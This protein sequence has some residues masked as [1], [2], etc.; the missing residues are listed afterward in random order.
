MV[1]CNKLSRNDTN[2]NALVTTDS[3]ELE[4]VQTP[5]LTNTNEISLND[6]TASAQ[7]DPQAIG[8]STYIETEVVQ[9]DTVSSK[10]AYDVNRRTIEQV[11]T[12]GATTTYQVTRKV[13]KKTIKVDTIVE[14]MDKE[15]N[16][17]YQKGNYQKVDE[18]VKQDT[19]VEAMS[20]EEARKLKENAPTD[21]QSNQGSASAIKQNV[22]RAT[23][24]SQEQAQDSTSARDAIQQDM[25]RANTN[26]RNSNNQT[27]AQD[28]T[29]VE[30]ETETVVTPAPRDTT[31]M[32]RELRNRTNKQDTTSGNKSS[33]L[34]R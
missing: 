1:S 16:V 29:N 15:E 13:I 26:T 33:D 21:D 28:S 7:I 27:Q 22:P 23:T 14:T 24:N 19:V 12:V 18:T 31:T 10:V 4:T 20:V 8:D 34:N 32:S 25:P 2:E 30:R 17:A 9:I 5:N 3:L 11:D 6:S